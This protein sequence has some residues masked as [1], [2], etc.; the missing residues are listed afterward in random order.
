MLGRWRDADGDVPVDATARLPDGTELTGPDDLKAALLDRKGLFLRNL[1]RR[2]LGYAL[3][4]GL[5]S[6][7]ACAVETIIR[8]V[9]SQ[10]YAAWALV[11]GVVTSGPF[12][13]L[14]PEAAD[15][16]RD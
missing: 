2:M 16:G 4:R 12:L 9:K 15:S 3:G 10:E 7:D 11:R 13:G 1:T 8:D 5:T 14:S 6:A